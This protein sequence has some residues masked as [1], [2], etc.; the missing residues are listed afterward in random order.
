[1]HPLE[2]LIKEEFNKIVNGNHYSVKYD[3]KCII[4]TPLE[5]I[6]S[7]FVMDFSLLRDFINNFSD[8]LTI[9]PV[10]GSGTVAHQIM[11]FGDKLEATVQLKP[12]AN[13][14]DY[15]R[16]ETEKIKEY[17]FKAIL[18]DDAVEMI[19]SNT[20]SDSKKNQKNVEDI[21]AI[22]IQ[23]V[24][25]IQLK[26][27]DMT[28]GTIIRDVDPVTAIRYILTKFSK[29]EG[30]DRHNRVRG[31]DFAPGASREVRD[32]IKIPHLTP[33]IRIP[34]VI[35]RIVGGVY[36]TGFQYYLQQDMWFIF[37][38]YNTKTF[39]QS[40][41][42]LTVINV[43]KDK[44]A[45]AER[46]FRL[47]PTQ[48]IAL[49]TGEVKFQRHSF[50]KDINESMGTR[51]VDA[52]RVM[53]EFGITGGNKF[54]V[55]R[56]ANV[57]EYTTSA[58]SQTA[59]KESFVKITSKHNLERTQLAYRNGA[60]LQAVWENSIDDLLYPGM[61]VRFIYMVRNEPKQVYG[62]L[63]AVDSTYVSESTSFMQRKFMNRSILTF[64][65]EDKVE[66][67]DVL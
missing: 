32:H 15:A 46:S 8:I 21:S 5:D 55:N 2:T 53:N 18:F 52:G 17:R 27:R 42:T 37:S 28:Y 56:S 26:L 31:V 16:S 1:M 61:P 23:L 29:I 39:E 20:S 50:K 64:F 10:Y 63:C 33:V 3:I 30:S 57:N 67:E 12:L 51:Y 14:P 48:V 44:L 60:I 11:P 9:T 22:N 19:Q 13:I 62:C 58:N 6:E 59:A 35:D 4:H 43:T 38:P 49:S 41:S 54:I 45:Q 47:T 25:P 66:N 34:M 36:P 7:L 40:E 24:N 65:V